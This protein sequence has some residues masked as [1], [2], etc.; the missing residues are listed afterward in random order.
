MPSIDHQRDEFTNALPIWEMVGAADEGAVTRADRIKKGKEFLI[1][2]DESEKHKDA[3]NKRFEKYCE[4]AVWYS[5]TSRTLDG[6]QGQ[7]FA[8]PPVIE[9]PESLKPMLSDMDGNGLTFEQ[10]SKDT[11]RDVAKDGRKILITD[12]PKREADTTRQEIN[13][14]EVKPTIVEYAASQVINW[15]TEQRGSNIV[16]VLLVIADEMEEFSEEDPFKPTKME[17][18]RV[19]SLD[20]ENKYTVE[21]YK[22]NDKADGSTED[23]ILV[24]DAIQPIDGSGNFFDYIPAS[25]VGSSNNNWSIDKSPISSIATLNFS[26]WQNSAEYEEGIRACGNFTPWVSG[27]D[28]NWW[29]NVLGGRIEMGP[30]GGIGLPENGEAGLL[31]A[32]ANSVAFEAMQHKERQMVALGGKIVQDREVQRTLGEAEMENASETSILA[33][34]ANNVEAAYRQQFADALKFIEGGEPDL[35]KFKIEFNRDYSVKSITEGML[36]ELNNVRVTDGMSEQQ[37]QKI[38]EKVSASIGVEPEESEE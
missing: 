38:I 33:S 11:L 31:Q 19:F 17:V 2:P 6:L 26:H 15:R 21:I 36:R 35:D 23:F 37:F 16:L 1:R 24:E 7:V 8:K 34:I 22:K 4:G 12:Y 20:A 27:I 3:S 25:C 29:K 32:E 28:E 14:G 18:W 13:S 30:S 10:Q 9:I 5:I